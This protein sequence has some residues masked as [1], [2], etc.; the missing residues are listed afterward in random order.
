MDLNSNG[1]LLYPSQPILEIKTSSI[2]AFKFKKEDGLFKLVKDE[3]NHPVV[4]APGDKK[5]K[6]F[7]A[8]GNMVIPDEYKYQLGLYC[9]LRNTEKGMF[10]VCFLET[11][12]YIDPSKT[13]VNEREIYLVDFK[14]DLNEFKKVISTA[15]KWYLD[16]I[17]TG[18]SP[19][20]SKEDLEWFNEQIKV[21]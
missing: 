3:N 1:N 20:L 2:D 16:F 6:W 15:E 12:D 9:Y 21:S 11:D 13:D 17:K 5:K 19:K 10:A 18:I 14:I 8:S 4:K 7:D